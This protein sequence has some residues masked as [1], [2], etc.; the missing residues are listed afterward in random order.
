MKKIL[1]GVMSLLLVIP[2]A[3]CGHSKQSGAGVAQAATK[4][5]N[6]KSKQKYPA[7]VN[8]IAK[9]PAGRTKDTFT[10][11][12]RSVQIYLK[13]NKKAWDKF[14]GTNP[15]F[16][17]RLI[18]ANRKVKNFDAKDVKYLMIHPQAHIRLSV[19]QFARKNG[20]IIILNRPN[21]KA[22]Y[23]RINQ[24]GLNQKEKQVL[25]GLNKIGNVFYLKKDGSPVHVKSIAQIGDAKAWS[26]GAMASELKAVSQKIKANAPS[27]L[28]VINH[29]L[30]LTT[31]HKYQYLRMPLNN[32]K[33]FYTQVEKHGITTERGYAGYYGMAEELFMYNAVLNH[34]VPVVFSDGY[35]HQLIKKLNQN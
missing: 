27:R 3:A 15:Q 19:S 11:F 34:K 29:L 7:I 9:L 31:A 12:P 13:N 22:T 1:I 30:T 32:A 17:Q 10:K 23:Q 5:K 8:F 18:E 24:N 21:I 6:T 28:K 16:S 35:N 20:K 25:A 33:R 4:T 26:T 2:M 14:V